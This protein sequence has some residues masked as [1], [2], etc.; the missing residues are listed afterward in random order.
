MKLLDFREKLAIIKNCAK[1]K[2]S[3]YYIT[4]DFSQKV[5]EIRSK[6]WDCT[7]ENKKN[8]EKVKL[9][10]DKVSIN[11]VLYMW[12]DT[13]GSIVRFPKRHQT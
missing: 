3:D 8:K 13:S 9:I 1:L 10:F 12:D 6:L 11:D 2:G 7:A 5:R 4:E